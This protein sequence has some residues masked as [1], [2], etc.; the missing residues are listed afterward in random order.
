MGQQTGERGPKIPIINLNG[1]TR[2]QQAEEIIHLQKQI[3]LLQAQ[4]RNKD[5]PLGA[6]LE[7]NERARR[8][9]ENEFVEEQWQGYEDNSPTKRRRHKEK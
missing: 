9:T 4:L 7:G 3:D 2:I 8:E 1:E 5:D 6:E